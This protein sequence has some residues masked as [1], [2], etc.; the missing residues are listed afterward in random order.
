MKGWKLRSLVIRSIAAAAVT[1]LTFFSAEGSW[2]DNAMLAL[3]FLLN[4]GLITIADSFSEIANNHPRKKDVFYKWFGKD[5]RLEHLAH[6]TKY[7]FYSILVLH[8]NSV[9]PEFL[10]FIATGLGVAGLNLIMWRW[11]KT[12]SKL[13]WINMI[14]INLSTLSLILSFGFKLFEVKYAEY[15]LALTGLYHQNK[16]NK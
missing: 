3:N 4:L 1:V 13:W 15:L 9:I 11:Y 16:T 7:S 12:W 5:V 2:S 10:H 14:T 8:L 6:F